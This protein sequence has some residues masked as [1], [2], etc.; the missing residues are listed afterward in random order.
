MQSH[1]RCP[2]SFPRPDARN[3]KEVSGQLESETTPWET[4][5]YNYHPELIPGGKDISTGGRELNPYTGGYLKE[6]I[7]P[8][9]SQNF[10]TYN[11]TGNL[12]EFSNSRGIS[13]SY[14]FNQFNELKREIVTAPGS[15]SPLN[16][17]ADYKKYDDNGNLEI[18][19]TYFGLSLANNPSG[20][21]LG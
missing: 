6:I 8:L 7:S 14:A 12:T 20:R 10:K 4:T 19:D 17:R 13:A 18:K 1:Y 3:N 5:H 21:N 9:S 16:Y 11:E 2:I 15:F